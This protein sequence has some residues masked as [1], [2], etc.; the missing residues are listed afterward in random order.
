MNLIYYS[1][2]H[3]EQGGLTNQIFAFITSI[4]I[5]NVLT[6]EKAIIYEDFLCDYKGGKK[7]TISNIFDLQ[8]MNI[9]LKKNLMLLFL[10]KRM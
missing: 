4:L 8:K 9:Y 3:E 2:I 7:E 5:A 10:I 6:H 1:K